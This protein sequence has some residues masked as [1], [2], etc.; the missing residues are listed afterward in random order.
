MAY[1]R[2]EK[3]SGGGFRI[4]DPDTGYDRIHV[5]GGYKEH[6]LSLLLTQR[7]VIENMITSWKRSISS[8]PISG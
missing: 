6:S 7:L 4:K 8:W 5:F 1:I 3:L 2:V